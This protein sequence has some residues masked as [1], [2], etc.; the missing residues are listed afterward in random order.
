VAAAVTII[1]CCAIAPEAEFKSFAIGEITSKVTRGH[2]NW[3][4][5]MGMTNYRIGSQP[6][7]HRTQVTTGIK[8]NPDPNTN[9]NST[10]TLLTL[11]TL[12]NPNF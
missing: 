10:L 7:P 6:R 2:R 5:S 4:Y 8:P 12:L 3:Q 11:P 9:P 1:K